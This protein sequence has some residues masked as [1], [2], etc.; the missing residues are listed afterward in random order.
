MISHL[1]I[2]NYQDRVNTV[3]LYGWGS[4]PVTSAGGDYRLCWC[5]G[6]LPC[7]QVEDFR[8]DM[9]QF[10]LVGPAPLL[11]H[12]TCVSGQTCE[13]VATMGQHLSD[14]DRLQLL[15]TCGLEV[16][17]TRFAGDGLM[18]T[19]GSDTG[20]KFGL[21]VNTAQGG[22]YRLCWCAS[23][24]NCHTSEHFRVDTG[25]L[26]MIGP[27]P[28]NQDR[29]CVSGQTCVVQS[30]SGFRMN[31]ADSL[32]ILDTC[33]VCQPGEVCGIDGVVERFPHARLLVPDGSM[34][35]TATHLSAKG[36]VYRL[37]WCSAEASC[38]GYETF[39]VDMGAMLIVGPRALDRQYTCVS[40][41]E[42][43][44]RFMFS[45]DVT[46]QRELQEFAD[47]DQVRIL[48]TCGHEKE[49][50]VA[51]GQHTGEF[52]ADSLATR[53][54][55]SGAVF[56]WDS[57]LLG[58]AGGRYR[59]CWCA[60]S[61]TC[62]IPSEFRVDMGELVLL[63]P[64]TLS[65]QRTC[66]S[67]RTCTFSFE[68]AEHAQ[69]VVH[70]GSMVL[71]DTCANNMPLD[72]TRR[73]RLGHV[74]HL[75]SRFPMDT[76][77]VMNKNSQEAHWGAPIITS[78]GGTYRLCWCAG[79]PDLGLL[80][81]ANASAPPPDANA[82]RP[83]A[84]TLAAHYRVDIGS[85]DVIGPTPLSQDR[86]CISG[87]TCVLENFYGHMV[88]TT[89]MFLILDTCGTI[90]RELLRFAQNGHLSRTSLVGSK[91][92][93]ELTPAT[94]EWGDTP[95]TTYGGQY[96]ICWCAGG[97]ICSTT[98]HYALDMGE[99]TVVGVS[100]LYQSRTC[101]AGLTCQFDGFVGVG[102]TVEDH[103][104][105]L[106]TCGSHTVAARSAAATSA[107]IATQALMGWVVYGQQPGPTPLSATGATMSFG[108]AAITAGGG[109][110]RLCWC[111]AAYRCSTAEDFRVD[112][113]EMVLVGPL[114]SQD[115]TC[116]AGQTCRLDG[117]LGQHISAVDKIVVLDSCGNA[118]DGKMAVLMDRRWPD[119]GHLAVGGSGAMAS[120]GTVP[121][122]A[123]GGQYRL[124]WCAS[125]AGTC[126]LAAHY[127]VTVGELLLLG[128]S[129]LYQHRTCVSG[130]HCVTHSIEPSD[131]RLG[132]MTDASGLPIVA[133]DTIAVLDTCGTDITT[134]P[135]APAAGYIHS[136][137]ATWN[138]LTMG[139]SHLTAQGG[140]YRLCWCARN[141]PCTVA[142]TFRVDMGE[143]TV[144]GPRPLYQDRTCI[145]GQTCDVVNFY[146][147]SL[148][149]MD[150]QHHGSLGHLQVLDTCGTLQHGTP[151]YLPL[152]GEMLVNGGQSVV[153]FAQTPLTAPGGQYRLCWCAVGY[154]CV[155]PS[156]FRTD[157][158]ELLLI[159]V[160][161]LAQDRTCISGQT[162]R[163]DGIIGFHLASADRVFVLDTCH[164]PGREIER[165]RFPNGGMVEATS[166][167]GAVVSWGTLPITAA[168][169]QYRLCWCAGGGDHGA[170][171]VFADG[172]WEHACEVPEAFHVD[173]G[174]LTV[175]GPWRPSVEGFG[176]YA[177]QDRTC[178]S[179]QTCLFSNIRGH[180]LTYN[181]NFL[182]LDSCGAQ[183]YLHRVPRAGTMDVSLMCGCLS[184]DVDTDGDGVKDCFDECPQDP[185]KILPGIC[186]CGMAD[187]D[188]DADGS[189]DCM[190][191]CPM[192]PLKAAVTGRCGC[193]VSEVDSDGDGAPDCIDRCPAD[194]LKKVY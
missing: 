71:L 63:G 57:L 162:C 117:F 158:G 189:P 180:L 43:A 108:P 130:Q 124:C 171:L 49:V 145:S 173:M 115:R 152:E 119:S 46:R 27:A 9:G 66:V 76:F 144:I 170:P 175:I 185:D 161:P 84:C 29:T 174:R 69:S 118:A 100:P 126:H 31:A 151:P 123:K 135:R 127:R 12:R 91:E 154:Q 90:V 120:F 67:G 79:R 26:L 14:G 156:D 141:F 95:I 38:T 72:H 101:V 7:D 110:Y 37:C 13:F 142:E 96:R 184:A 70:S 122:T 147:H 167:T 59:L 78:I 48:D 164:T 177:G 188:T 40:G 139:S 181:E 129:P 15:D 58:G 148:T 150:H 194:P 113:G 89:D 112:F 34:Q 16:E 168:G 125:A 105:V 32:A 172:E 2:G 44:L 30:L 98:E 5:S 52:A 153:S 182:M 137:V 21:K 146:V 1:S 28:L 136:Q 157:M 65:V 39:R 81:A 11:D 45:D 97:Y 107:A 75:A 77:E 134:L 61:F 193:G 159:G 93:A 42:C 183:E 178:I 116:V 128:P 86:T 92:S 53:V 35:W 73:N 140:E 3:D 191:A 187:N 155:N 104:M 6:T 131:R 68:N 186:G 94:S 23:G 111:A 56:S 179:G 121:V 99:L 190:D 83:Y 36:G 109:Q 163:L 106:E 55:A 165:R 74:D 80:G 22:L 132:L 24:F 82:T 50:N 166:A 41:Q 143:L 169:G 60:S 176:G 160:A 133:S 149:G 103:V 64:S 51:T 20:T 62:D 102:L 88:A 10:I 138:Y 18:T 25:D 4:V 17:L 85:L 19:L 192:D 8:V 33:G 114:W 47:G 87:Q 54:Q